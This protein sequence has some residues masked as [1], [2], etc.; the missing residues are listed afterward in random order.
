MI[1]NVVGTIILHVEGKQLHVTPNP[2]H[3]ITIAKMD[4]CQ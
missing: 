3:S 1:A 2:K 4:G